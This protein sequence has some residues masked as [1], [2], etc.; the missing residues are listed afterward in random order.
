MVDGADPFDAHQ[1]GDD[2]ADVKGGPTVKGC[3]FLPVDESERRR[4]DAEDV[5]RGASRSEKILHRMERNRRG[6]IVI[7]AVVDLLEKGAHVGTGFNLEPGTQSHLYLVDE[8]DVQDLL[9]EVPMLEEQPRNGMTVQLLV[10][11]T[12]DEDGL[13]GLGGVFSAHGERPFLI[14]EGLEILQFHQH[15]VTSFLIAGIWIQP[16]GNVRNLVG[17]GGGFEPDIPDA[18][19]V[20]QHNLAIVFRGSR[21]VDED[22]IG[23]E[24]RPFKGHVA[25]S[26]PGEQIRHAGGRTI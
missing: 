6:H 19:D 12:V 21:R 17:L 8:P 13:H 10:I 4:L 9:A 1:N 11:V 23:W 5:L 26:F 22:D 16:F 3:E 7:D 14:D 24:Q 15:M 18:G 25:A 2:V 20:L